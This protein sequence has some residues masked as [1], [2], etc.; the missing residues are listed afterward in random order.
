[1]VDLEK[2][3]AVKWHDDMMIVPRDSS[4]YAIYDDQYNV[5]PLEEQD[6]YKEDWLGLRNLTE[7]GDMTFPIIPGDH[8]HYDHSTLDELVIPVLK[9]DTRPVQ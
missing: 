4:H 9:Q 3:V 2:V 6:L 7:R 1:M 5:I 8:M